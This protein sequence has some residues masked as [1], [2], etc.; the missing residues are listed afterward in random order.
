MWL[1]LVERIN[2]HAKWEKGVSRVEKG[3]KETK[4]ERIKGEGKWASV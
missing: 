4:E 2:K 3:G 1:I